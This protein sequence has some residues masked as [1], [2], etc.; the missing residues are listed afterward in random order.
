MS[1]PRS[2][3]WEGEGQLGHWRSV[4]AAPLCTAWCCATALPH[5]AC[6]APTPHAPALQM[7]L[8]GKRLLF[9]SGYDYGQDMAPLVFSRGQTLCG[10][11]EPPLASIDGVP[12]C[13]VAGLGELQVCSSCCAAST[14]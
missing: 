4:C 11:N 3:R 13:E 7:L 9:V 1:G 5:P 2:S 12:H 10:W 14:G 8:A 6:P